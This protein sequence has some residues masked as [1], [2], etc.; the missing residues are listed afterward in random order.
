MLPLSDGRDIS[1][2]NCREAFVELDQEGRLTILQEPL[3]E[4]VRML[5]Q[6]LLNKFQ[7]RLKLEMGA[8]LDGSALCVRGELRRCCFW[9][10]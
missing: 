7:S 10:P 3:D 5:E 9:P 4:I 1:I 6:N 2:S 8:L